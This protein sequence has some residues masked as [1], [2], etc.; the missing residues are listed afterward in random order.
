MVRTGSENNGNHKAMQKGK[1]RTCF[2]KLQTNKTQPSVCVCVCAMFIVL[3]ISKN[4]L[5]LFVCVCVYQTRLFT[6]VV[7]VD[8]RKASW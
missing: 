1:T 3:V 8:W 4:V 2:L 7:G 5:H 6:A